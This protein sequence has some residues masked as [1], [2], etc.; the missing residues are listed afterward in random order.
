MLD[1]DPR[2]KLIDA[3]DNY[4]TWRDEK[5]PDGLTFNIQRTMVLDVVDEWVED[6]VNYDQVIIPQPGDCAGDLIDKDYL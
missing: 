2:E 1:K 4:A 5:D 3:I 6:N